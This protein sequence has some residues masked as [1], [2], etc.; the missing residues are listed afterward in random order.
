LWSIEK[1]VY[2]YSKHIE[3]PSRVTLITSKIDKN[4]K[5]QSYNQHVQNCPYKVVKRINEKFRIFPL[6]LASNGSKSLQENLDL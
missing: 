4:N 1:F 6:P 3:C 2:T 5:E